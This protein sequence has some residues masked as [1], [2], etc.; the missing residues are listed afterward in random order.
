RAAFFWAGAGVATLSAVIYSFIKKPNPHEAAVAIDRVLGLKEI[1]ST[2]L[3][4]RSSTDPFARATVSAAERTA[5]NVSLSKRFPLA[6]PRSAYWS[7]AAGALVLFTIWLLPSFDLFGR[8]AKHE[9]LAEQQVKRDEAKKTVER[10]LATVSSYPKAL[11]SDQAIQ[12]ARKDLEALL[13]KPIADPDRATRTA[14]KALEQSNDALK[15]EIRKSSQYAI[16]KSNE[17]MLK[18]L[19]PPT[20]AQGPV[21]DA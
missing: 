2:A 17:K 13:N 20:D 14:F 19:N 5:D 16:A 11:Q 18:S 9:A 15:E 12:M 4:V 8:Q 1:F 21:A 7:V 6:F 3:F 10:A